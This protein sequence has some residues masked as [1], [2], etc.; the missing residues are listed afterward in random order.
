MKV[1]AV[2]GILALLC[3]AALAQTADISGTWQGGSDRARHVLKISKTKTG[4]RGDFYNLG[5]SK[6]D[7][8]SGSPRNGNGIS[9]IAMSGRNVS[10]SLD[11]TQGSFEG[12]L[13]DDGGGLT[14]NLFSGNQPLEVMSR[15][16]ENIRRQAHREL[17]Q[18]AARQGNGVLAHTHFG[19]LIKREVEKQPDEYLGRH[20][21]IGTVVEARR[22]DRITFGIE[23]VVD[24]QG[25]RS[26]LTR[27]ATEPPLPYLNDEQEG[28]I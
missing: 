3:G 14:G 18:D 17:R 10:F 6:G 22:G 27:D 4:W 20:I 24:M 23:T 19:Q 5:D 1:F 12:T 25:D 28:A 11:E 21:V 16:W 15:F 2:V 8:T 9:T 26:P 13:S 7:E